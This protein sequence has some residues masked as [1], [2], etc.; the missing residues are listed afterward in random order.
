MHLLQVVQ[1]VKESV[2]RAALCIL[3]SNESLGQP[4]VESNNLTRQ[5]DKQIEYNNK[6]PGTDYDECDI[7]RGKAP[8][9]EPVENLVAVCIHP[10]N[11]SR[12]ARIGALL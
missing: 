4:R 8:R 3:V 7:E 1:A 9:S 6:L 10:T 5:G 12:T 2:K 11:V